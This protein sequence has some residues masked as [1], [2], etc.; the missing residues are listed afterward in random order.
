MVQV[1]DS[2]KLQPALPALR[3][4]QMQMQIQIQICIEMAGER[5]AANLTSWAHVVKLLV[6]IFP[7]KPILLRS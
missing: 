6:T 7:T 4:V 3:S 2:L 5:R 1:L